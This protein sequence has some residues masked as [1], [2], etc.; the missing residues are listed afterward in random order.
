MCVLV[1]FIPSEKVSCP[2]RPVRHAGRVGT[3]D[4]PSAILDL[5]NQ[6]FF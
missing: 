4:P 5:R 6:N 1:I 2:T 3:F